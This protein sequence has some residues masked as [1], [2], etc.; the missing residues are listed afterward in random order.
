[1]NGKLILIPTPISENETYVT[2]IPEISKYITELKFFVVEEIRTARRF[3]RSISKD[4]VID[5]L[6]FFVLNEHNMASIPDE[7][8]AVL[9]SG[10]S[11]GLMSEAGC[12]AVADPGAGLVLKCH[13]E[14]IEMIPLVGP[15][16]ILL[17]LMASGLSGQYFSFNGY[18]P[19]KSNERQ[20]YINQLNKNAMNSGHTQIYIEAPYRNKQVFDDLV[21][22]GNPSLLLCVAMD[23]TGSEQYIK[24]A[25][26]RWWSSHTLSLGKLPCIFLI[27]KV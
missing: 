19:A 2:Q 1:M 5:E 8:I 6:K 22:Y 23:I 27:G 24:T 26:I 12:P 16:S 11:V 4:V 20:K 3:I 13:I 15:S 25:P 17:A 10:H 21:K 9:R 7:V 18:M 14:G